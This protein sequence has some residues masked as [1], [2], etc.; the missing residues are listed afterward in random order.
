M[1]VDEPT[2]EATIQI[3]RGIKEKYE[4]HHGIHITDDACVAAA[5]LSD[6]YISDRSLPDLSLIHI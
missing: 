5:V 1:L 6:R 4:A 2:V 3:L